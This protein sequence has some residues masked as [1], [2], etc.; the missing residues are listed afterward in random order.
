MLIKVDDIRKYRQIAKNIDPARVEIYI[1]EAEML[2]LMPRIGA[3]FYQKLDNI[4]DIVLEE[5]RKKLKDQDGET[6]A[7]EN[8]YDLPVNEWKFL[9]GGYYRTCEGEKRFFGGV[10][11]AL[12]YYAYARFVRNHSQQVTPFGVV[13]KMGDESSGVDISTV[14]AM[15]ADARRIADEYMAQSLAFWNEVRKADD[16]R[17]GRGSERRRFIPIGE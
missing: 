7:V 5:C 3:E 11:T 13:A 12:C 9:N 17:A 14:A 8:E 6:I 10:R 16:I 2:D 4:G 1:K 15:S